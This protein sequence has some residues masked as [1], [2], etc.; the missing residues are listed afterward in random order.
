MVLKASYRRGQSILE[1]VVLLATLSIMVIGG[2]GL[3]GTSTRRRL[4]NVNSSIQINNSKNL[5]TAS[6]SHSG[7]STGQSNVPIVVNANSL[8]TN[9]IDSI[10]SSPQ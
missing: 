7:E 3:I 4:T 1:N 6:P 10:Q 8:M 5:T 9:S 2:V